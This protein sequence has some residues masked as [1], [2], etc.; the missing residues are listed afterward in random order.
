[1]LKARKSL[2]Y[3]TRAAASLVY[4]QTSKT[5]VLAA[6]RILPCA[7]GHLGRCVAKM[8]AWTRRNK[9]SATAIRAR[10]SSDSKKLLPAGPKVNLCE[11]RISDA[12]A[13]FYGCMRTEYSC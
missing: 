10:K 6:A 5:A 3:R 4:G 1:M 8:L 13:K 7:E 12:P 11:I 9:E 2:N